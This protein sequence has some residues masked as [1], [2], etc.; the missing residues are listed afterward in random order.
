MKYYVE[1]NSLKTLS[2]NKVLRYLDYCGKIDN[3][4]IMLKY[5]DLRNNIYSI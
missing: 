1:T 2:K 4:R 3:C 5:I